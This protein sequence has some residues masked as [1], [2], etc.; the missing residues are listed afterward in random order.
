M[1]RDGN[2]VRVN[3][4]LIN[5][6]NDQHLWAEVYE[7][8]LT[9]V[10]AIQSA[11]AE[12]IASATEGEAFARRKSALHTKP[13]ENHDA[14]LLYVQARTLATGSDTEERK[15][16]IPLFEQAIALDPN[17]AHRPRAAVV[18]RELALFLGRSNSRRGWR[19]HA[20]RRKRRCGSQP[21]LPETHLALGF[22]HY[23]GERDYEKALSEF[24]IAHRGL[25]N[26]ADILRAQ[27]ARSSGA[28]ANGSESTASYRK[29]VS[30]NPQGRG[31]DP[32]SRAELSSRLAII[33]TAARTFDRA[34]KLAPDD[35]EIKSLR[36]WVDVYGTAISR[37]FAQLLAEIAGRASDEPGRG[38]GSIQCAILRAEV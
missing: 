5:T 16:A 3:V 32:E 8:D 11:L 34:V 15:N 1:R 38:A 26:D 31:A 36:A 21:D 12:E 4:Q 20:P 27:S 14:Y 18:A 25:P 10:F 2:R 28:R 6:S 19:R 13:T 22:L 24:A 35:F 23:Y 30:L 29:A 9:D 37:A 17:F 33:A 7:R